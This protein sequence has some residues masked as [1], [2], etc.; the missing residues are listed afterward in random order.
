M[1]SFVFVFILIF[2]SFGFQIDNKSILDEFIKS[3]ISGQPTFHDIK[4]GTRYGL[5]IENHRDKVDPGLYENYIQFKKS[6]PIRQ[7]SVVTPAG[8]FQLWIPGHDHR[9]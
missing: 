4:C 3:E 8:F 2:N 6:E 1:R 7:R 9:C 5:A